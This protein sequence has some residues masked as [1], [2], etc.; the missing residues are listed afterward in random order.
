L[1]LIV[2]VDGQTVFTQEIVALKKNH[3]EESKVEK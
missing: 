2:H 1:S 3:K